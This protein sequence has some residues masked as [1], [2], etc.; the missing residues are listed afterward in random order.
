MVFSKVT[1]LLVLVCM[2]GSTHAQQ[3]HKWV[4]AQG[5]THYGNQPPLGQETTTVK[6]SNA[7]ANVGSGTKPIPKDVQEL[8]NGF[9]IAIRKVDKTAVP[10]SCTKAVENVQYQADQMI[11]TAEKNVK[12]GYFKTSDIQ[13]TVDT[14]K[15]ARAQST[16]SDCESAK[17][18]RRSFYECMSS[19]KNHVLG[20]GTKFKS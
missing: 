7:P 15:K 3:V 2:L 8:M 1:V 11:A 13:S 19:D 12:D 14:I 9:D 4:D 6:T 5:K 20:C 10:L 17:G 16:V 18:S